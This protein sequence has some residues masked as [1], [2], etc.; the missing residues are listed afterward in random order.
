M[1]SAQIVLGLEVELDFA[2]NGQT[3]NVFIEPNLQIGNVSAAGWDRELWYSR[4]LPDQADSLQN[5]LEM[6]V[7]S[8]QRKVVA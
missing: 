4:I 7:R 3:A 8:T 6:L 5:H 2:Q 1:R